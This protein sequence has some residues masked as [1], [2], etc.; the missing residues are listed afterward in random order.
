MRSTRSLSTASTR[1]PP[2]TPT[3]GTASSSSSSTCWA[4]P[5]RSTGTASSRQ[6]V[7]FF[8]K[9]NFYFSLSRL[10]ARANAI[11]TFFFSLFFSPSF[12]SPFFPSPLFQQV[13]TDF[14][15]GV[16]TVNQ[17]EVPGLTVGKKLLWA[18][19]TAKASAAVVPAGA[20]ATTNVTTAAEGASDITDPPPPVY[21]Y[22]FVLD[23]AGSYW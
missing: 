21:I 14:Q 22:D 17:V 16:G 12:L 15:D 13:N 10:L 23:S 4:G 1:P 3:P 11:L 2:F 8:R 20:A 9:I 5:R 19:P 7:F 6:V 18:K